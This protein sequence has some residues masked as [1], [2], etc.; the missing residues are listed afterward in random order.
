MNLRKTAISVQIVLTVLTGYF[1]CRKKL[2]F[3]TFYNGFYVI[4]LSS[5]CYCRPNL[6]VNMDGPFVMLDRY[7]CS[8]GGSKM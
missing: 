4:I 7:K 5:V 3:K 8:T 6:P 1:C 2:F